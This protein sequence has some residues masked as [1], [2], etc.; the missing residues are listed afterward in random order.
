M[1]PSNVIRR[2]LL[3]HPEDSVL[4]GPWSSVRWSFVIDIGWAGSAQYADWSAKIGC[5][6][7]SLYSFAEWHEDVPRIQQLCGIGSNRLVDAEGIDWWELLAPNSYQQVYEFLL[8]Q[9]VARE[10]QI[11]DEVR[12]TRPH[13]LADMLGELLAVKVNPV[14]A[15]SERSTSAR[16][17]RFTTKLRTLTSAQIVQIA[18]DK[19]D[20]DYGVRRLFSKPGQSSGSGKRVLLPS[21]Y[22][23]VSRVLT[24]YAGLLP[25]RSFLLVTTRADGKVKDRPPNMGATSLAA[26]APC[27]RNKTTEREI[28]FLTRQWQIVKREL[29]EAHPILLRTPGLFES[30]DRTLQ[31]CLRMRDAWVGVFERE[32]IDCVLCA[33]ENNHYTRVPVLLARR[34]GVHTVYCSH[35]ALDVNILLR[36]MCSETYLAKGEME[37]DYLVQECR[38]PRER[39]VIG[40]PPGPDFAA[41]GEGVATHIAFFSEPYELYYGR[42]ETLYRELLPRLCAIA[43][44][45]GRKVMVK[46]HPFES[47]AERSQLVERVLTDAD[48]TDND[49]KLVEVIADPL[50]ERMLRKIWFSLTVASSVAVECALAGVPSFLCG[51]FDIDLYSYGKQY[52]RFGAARILDDP[53]DIARIPELIGSQRLSAEVR[54][55]LYSPITREDFEAVLQGKAA[56]LSK[57]EPPSR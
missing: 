34:R 3:L 6:V 1:P 13:R 4:E 26:Y 19:W 45:H 27:P 47:L 22:R 30:F 49:R 16:F 28:A 39:I 44:E 51:W 10:L 55:R 57:Q 7:R 56:A 5:P 54:N 14:I 36:G 35:G 33:D 12:V 11:P 41:R 21:A 31:N 46:L 43:R 38:I 48:L 52:E 15:Q 17:N 8:L 25:D 29:Y 9:K 23:N 18:F 50:S 53:E 32:E 42:T 37:S 40:G 24:K 2:L 20:G